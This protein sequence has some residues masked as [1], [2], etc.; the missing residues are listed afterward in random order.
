MN[1]IFLKSDLKENN[2]K[3]QKISEI[4]AEASD[5]GAFKNDDRLTLRLF[6][7][8]F[9]CS[10]EVKLHLHFDFSDEFRIFPL[11]LNEFSDYEDIYE[12]TID[13]KD[14]AGDSEGLFY[15][16]FKFSTQFGSVYVGNNG[17]VTLNFDKIS[18]EQL[19]VYKS[20]FIPPENFSDGIMYQIFVDRFFDGGFKILPGK[21]KVLYTDWYGKKFNYADVS[22][23]EVKNNDF[24]GGNLWGVA[25]KLDYLLS[26]GVGIIYLCPIFEAFSN[27]KYDTGDYSKVDKMFGEEEALINLISE[28][29]KRGIKII[30]DGVFNHTGDDSLYFNKYQNYETQGAYNSKK[31]QFYKWYKFED[32]PDK[33]ECWWGIKT[34]PSVNGDEPS[35]LQFICG[36]DGILRKYLR[37]G[38]DGWRLDVADELSDRFL[39][40]L[41][42]AVKSENKDALIIGEVWED[43]S[44][45]ISYGKRRRY[46]GGSQLDSVMN[47]PLK[48]G[49]I[50]YI[51]TK[52]NKTLIKTAKTLW[53]HYPRSVSRNLMNFLG[54]HD[55]ERILTV[56]ADVGTQHMTNRELSVFKLSDEQRKIAKKRLK[57]AW[58]LLVAFPGIPCIFYGDEAGIEGGHD[59]FCR[60]TYPWGREDIELLDYYKKISK[61]Y[62]SYMVFKKGNFQIV[63]TGDASRFMMIR[64]DISETICICVNLSDR[65]WNIAFENTPKR[66]LSKKMCDEVALLEAGEIEYFL[67]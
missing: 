61:I 2:L 36:E 8:R 13:L 5:L 52:N 41:R 14:I 38:I 16:Y 53:A 64:S 62:K 34:L 56:L 49:I 23:P 66:L 37:L 4:D 9:F 43:A 25:D 29:K 1:M 10:T 35:W 55:T 27:H 63:D 3:I 54:T 33:Y 44:N 42:G 51:L 40:E 22:C 30:L 20:D 58:A 7:P 48:E 28:C 31:S 6:V 18:K 57:L 19:L 60:M 11:L 12:V 45:K 17:T 67:L 15:Y 47:Y 32:F 46:F 65:V 39:C 50:S 59:P 26:L 24:Y 21:N